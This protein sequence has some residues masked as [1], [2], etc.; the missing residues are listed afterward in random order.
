[1]EDRFTGE[2]MDALDEAERKLPEGPEFGAGWI[3]QE[4]YEA[5]LDA[6]KMAREDPVYQTEMKE[7]LRAQY[8]DEIVVYRRGALPP[9][10]YVSVTPSREYAERLTLYGPLHTFRMRIRDAIIAFPTLENEIIVR[11]GNLRKE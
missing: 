7:A 11:V 3:K 9:K 10:G 4:D 5:L 8:G 1:M 2:T 6:V